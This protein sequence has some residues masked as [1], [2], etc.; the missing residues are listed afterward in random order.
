MIKNRVF[1]TD[2]FKKLENKLLNEDQRLEVEE[3]KERLK[4]DLLIGKMLRVYF[5]REKKLEEKR[6]YFLISKENKK[7]LFVFI[8]NKKHQKEDIERIFKNLEF[9][10]RLLST[11]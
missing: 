6:I 7:A 3:F 4:E 2:E 9:Y 11:P 5:V 8:G 10:K 1:K